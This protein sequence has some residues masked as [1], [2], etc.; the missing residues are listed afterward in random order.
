MR[1]LTQ[2]TAA[3]VMVF[4]ADATNALAGL[5]SLTL[6]ITA[7]KDGAAFGS[8]SPT[9]T[10]RGNGWYNL[11][12]TSSHT[13][14]LGDLAL[15]ITATGAVTQPVISRVIAWNRAVASIPAVA[16]G[17][18]GGLFIAG[19]NAATTANIT[20]NLTG[21]VSGSVGSVTGAV[22][23]VTG[24]VGSV[25]GAVGSVTGNVGGNVTGSVGSLTGHTNQT[26]DSFAR[27][28]A[29]AGASISADIAGID[30]GDGGDATLANQTTMLAALV[31]VQAAVYDS[32]SVSGDAITLS[33]AA[34]QTVTDS[35]R[36][37]A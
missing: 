31:K 33:N 3:N 1:E 11:A 22:G 24:A 20:G 35:G 8:I 32:A 26:G 18:S 2:S 34:T 4:M 23:S 17:A 29:P 5:A 36:V 14:T 37:T 30:A 27:L 7:S 13:D 28:G 21:N 19:S 10:D 16:A 15:N 12:L 6:T 9:V 25:T